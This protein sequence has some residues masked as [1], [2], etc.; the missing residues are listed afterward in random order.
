VPANRT[1]GMDH[2]HYAWSPLPTRPQLTWPGE[3]ALAF[4]VMVCLEHFDIDPPADSV[5][6]RWLSGGL[7]S[8]PFPNYARLSHREYGHRVGIF[9]LLDLLTR[10]Q[11]PV[12][13]AIDAMTAQG[14]PWL[15]ERLM[16][17]DVEIVCHGIAVTRM[18]SSKMDEATERRYIDESLDSLEQATGSRPVGWLGPEQGE[19]ERTPTLLAEAGLSYVCDW[20]NDE[21]PYPM[22]GGS[23][24]LLSMPTMLEYDDSFALVQ[25]RMTLGSYR[26][27]VI[28][29]ARQ[30]AEDGRKSGRFLLLCLRPWLIGQPFRIGVLEDILREIAGMD[31][32]WPARVGDVAAAYRASTRMEVSR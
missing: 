26:S 1:P 21:Q 31:L 25:R 15:L 18:V 10:F 7:G 8:R 23:G 20:S 27:A 19:S 12:T 30:M 5:Q 28:E 11:I 9:R 6:S 32:V 4:S 2:P 24:E 3:K 13:V 29:G 22:I 16:A 14:Y 17:H